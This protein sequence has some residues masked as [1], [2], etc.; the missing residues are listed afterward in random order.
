MVAPADTAA[1][2]AEELTTPATG[3]NVR[4]VAS[5]DRT[6]TEIAHVFWGRGPPLAGRSSPGA[7]SAM[8]KPRP[9]WKRTVCRPNL[10]PASLNWGPAFTAGSCGN[11]MTG[12]SP[13]MRWARLSRKTLP[14]SLPLA[15]SKGHFLRSKRLSLPRQ[16]LWV[17]SLAGPADAARRG[18]ARSWPRTC[19]PACGVAEPE[20]ERHG[21]NDCTGQGR[22]QALARGRYRSTQ[23]PTVAAPWPPSQSLLLSRTARLPAAKW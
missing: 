21:N 13:P 12:T 15:F 10:P 8:S 9:A 2:A 16:Q 17:F 19:C 5:D 3:Q 11:T 14:G 18:R 22:A 4:Y 7:P 23:G 1:A 6:A 20:A